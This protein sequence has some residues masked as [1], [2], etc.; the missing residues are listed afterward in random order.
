MDRT[1]SIEASSLSTTTLSHRTKFG[2]AIV[3]GAASLA[4]FAEMRRQQVT[5]AALHNVGASLGVCTL[6]SPWSV[7]CLINLKNRGFTGSYAGQQENRN[8]PDLGIVFQKIQTNQNA[9]PIL[10][11]Y[12]MWEVYSQRISE[13]KG[14]WGEAGYQD[15]FDGSLT[16]LTLTAQLMEQY[17]TL[18]PIRERVERLRVEV[19]GRITTEADPIK[20]QDLETRWKEAGW[21]LEFDGLL[22]LR[23]FALGAIR[24]N[25]MSDSLHGWAEELR[26]GMSGRIAAENDPEKV[27]QLRDAWTRAGWDI[28]FDG[29]LS[30]Y[31][32]TVDLIWDCPLNPAFHAKAEELRVAMV[33]RIAQGPDSLREA[34]EE[35]GL[36][37][38]FDGLIFSLQT[39][40]DLIKANPRHNFLRERAEEI[41]M[42]MVQRIADEQDPVREGSLRHLF[43]FAHQ[44]YLLALHPEKIWQPVQDLREQVEVLNNAATPSIFDLADYCVR[45]TIAQLNHLI[46]LL[47]EGK[48][49]TELQRA[50]DEG[51]LGLLQARH[52]IYSE[53]WELEDDE[54]LHHHF[55]EFDTLLGRVENERDWYAFDTLQ[56]EAQNKLVLIN[57]EILT[58][59]PNCRH[60]EYLL[61]AHTRWSNKLREAK[62]I[63][64]QVVQR[65]ADEQ[66]PEHLLPHLL[67]IA[68][69]EGLLVAYPKESWKPVQDLGDQLNLL[70]DQTT[71]LNEFDLAD[72]RIRGIIAELNNLIGQLPEGR[73]RTE[74]QKIVNEGSAFHQYA[75]SHIYSEDWEFC[76][77]EPLRLDFVNVRLLLQQLGS[78]IQ[79]R[80]W[81]A[82]DRLQT[83]A[84][85]RL[86]WINQEIL[87]REPNCRHTEYLVEAY[88]RWAAQLRDV[89]VKA[90]LAFGES[91]PQPQ[92]VARPQFVAKAQFLPIL[93]RF[94]E[95]ET[96]MVQGDLQKAN[97]KLRAAIDQY[98]SAQSELSKRR[99]KPFKILRD[100]PAELDTERELE[101]LRDHM[102]QRCQRLL[103]LYPIFGGE[104]TGA[105]IF[106]SWTEFYQ[107]SIKV[108]SHKVT[109][110]LLT[111]ELA[112]QLYAEFIEEAPPLPFKTKVVITNSTKPLVTKVVDTSQALFKV[113]DLLAEGSLATAKKELHSAETAVNKLR[114]RLPNQITPLLNPMTKQIS[115]LRALIQ[116]PAAAARELATSL[117]QRYEKLKQIYPDL[118]DAR[119]E[120]TIARFNDL[121]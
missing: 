115:E 68:E 99:N 63:R 80:D 121:S 91:L 48:T 59:E 19:V 34:W 38:E 32:L 25:P 79:R 86:V 35:A 54:P 76:N 84:H 73:T 119:T 24:A 18:S 95:V 117:S 104:R 53:G 17:P 105:Q 77:E 113:E 51:K 75:V 61:E 2:I 10:A 13:L 37:V 60:T 3:V 65:I 97:Q 9:L 110:H 1:H 92:P 44:A 71:S 70:R 5:V 40:L 81:E 52:R 98:E 118:R 33:E 74:L 96:A 82:V 55:K 28:E 27:A 106:A 107:N 42:Q 72:S 112:M 78:A 43:S 87:N 100:I 57:R 83:G 108:T 101:R 7:E 94:D 29:Q 4:V 69:L 12:G 22:T 23:Q 89:E 88:T 93:D 56:Q 85:E 39:A 45:G 47:P 64:L 120:E 15:G 58:R 6:L 20:R 41:R 116:A 90:L 62:E 31:Q 30:L 21:D 8:S 26:T 111:A 102:D 50:V 36:D 114:G 67:A 109:S 66:N 16:A 46:G 49:Q 11:R 14:L 103:L